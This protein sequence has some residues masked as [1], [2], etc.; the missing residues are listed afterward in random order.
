MVKLI[1]AVL[2]LLGLICFVNRALWAGGELSQEDLVRQLLEL[3]AKVAELEVRITQQEVK[4]AKVESELASHRRHIEHLIEEVGMTG[5]ITTFVQGTAHN[6]KNDP[7]PNESGEEADFSFSADIYLERQV[8]KHGLVHLYL[9]V[10]QGDL[11]TNNLPKTVSGPNADL[12]FNEDLIH[13]AEAWYQHSFFQDKVILTV[14]KLDPFG[15]FDTNSLA[16]DE[17]TQFFADIFVNN[18][19]AEFGGDNNNFGPGIVATY[20]PTQW[21]NFSLGFF[22]GEGDFDQ[23]F[24][25]PFGIFEIGLKPK[26]GKRAGN[27]RFYT[28]INDSFHKKI[29]RP[30]DDRKGNFG[31]GFSLDQEI[32]DKIATFSRFGIQNKEVSPFDLSWSIGLQINGS[33]FQRPKD[34]LGIAFGMSHPGRDFK[35]STHLNDPEKYFEA[36]YRLVVTDFLSISPDIQ[37]VTNPGGDSEADD[38]FLWGLRTRVDF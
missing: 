8:G 2:V 23:V 10:G 26:F 34:I 17:N 33:F 5:G 37:Y 18:L 11:V 14:G 27:Y 24:E 31:F 20:S 29:Q 7:N 4:R 36:Y 16:N 6:E 35:R 15:F 9:D 12:E 32:T 28:W 3:K 13:L 21:V 22:G 38:F 30:T 1:Q 25:E 19:M